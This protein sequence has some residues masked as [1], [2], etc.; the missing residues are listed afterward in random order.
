M[1]GAMG[2]ND[3]RDNSE[4]AEDLTSGK[5]EAAQDEEKRRLARMGGRRMTIGMLLGLLVGAVVG[6]YYGSANTGMV[7]GMLLGIAAG[8]A[9]RGKKD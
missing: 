8:C 7:L 4:N 9:W 5:P 2:E 6:Q 1:S 3:R